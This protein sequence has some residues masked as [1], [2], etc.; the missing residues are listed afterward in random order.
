M[1]TL[2]EDK[3]SQIYLWTQQICEVSEELRLL[4]KVEIDKLICHKEFPKRFLKNPALLKQG[5]TGDYADTM[6]GFIRN[7]RKQ[8]EKD[9]GQDW[10]ISD[11]RNVGKDVRKMNNFHLIKLV[12]SGATSPR[13]KKLIKSF[14]QLKRNIKKA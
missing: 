2:E 4:G 11:G 13:T 1:D 6:E 14:W 5:L 7:V 8:I 3:S 9:S 10:V 12:R